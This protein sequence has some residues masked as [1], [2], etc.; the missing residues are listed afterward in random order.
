MLKFLISVATVLLAAPLVA[1]TA[2]GPLFALAAMAT[3]ISLFA[4]LVCVLSHVRRLR[5]T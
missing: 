2:S 4:T 1:T 3:V 5:G